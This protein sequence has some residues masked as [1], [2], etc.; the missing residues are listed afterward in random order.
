MMARRLPKYCSFWGEKIY[1]R[2][3][4]DLTR[5]PDDPSSDDFREKYNRL[6][7]VVPNDKK[8]RP[9]KRM[10]KSELDQHFCGLERG[11]KSRAKR[12]GREYS[13]PK[14]WGADTYI[15]QGGLCAI[16]GLVMRKPLSAWDARGPSIDRKD[17]SQGYTPENCHLVTLAVN[18]AKSEMSYNEFIEFCQAVVKNYRRTKLEQKRKL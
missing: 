2:R 5:M 11:A 7:D 18:R 8:Q 4:G 9:S 6:I 10:T 13:L 1:F 12:V 15:S 14:Y 3:N 16:S 17:S